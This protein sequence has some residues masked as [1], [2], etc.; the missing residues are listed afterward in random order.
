VGSNESP[1]T[2]LMQR[3]TYRQCP[4]THAG[5]LASG[6]ETSMAK[7]KLPEAVLLRFWQSYMG[8]AHAPNF[9]LSEGPGGLGIC[10]KWAE[11]PYAYGPPIGPE[12]SDG[13][14]G[15]VQPFVNNALRWIPNKGVEVVY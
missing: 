2:P 5:A 9:N 15:V 13:Q 14:G 7:Y 8:A 11:N 4:A 3:K 12:V 1:L 10:K 6:N